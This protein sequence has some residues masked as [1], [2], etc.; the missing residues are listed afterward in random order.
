MFNFKDLPRSLFLLSL[1]VIA[2]GLPSSK[3]LMSLGQFGVVLAWILKGEYQHS[4][5]NFFT[6]KTLLV[7]SSLFLLHLIG[8]IYTQNFD[9][10]LRDVRVKLPIFILPFFSA[11][12]LPLK[13]REWFW[14]LHFFVLSVLFVS[15]IGFY[16]KF[17][18]PDLPFSPFVSHIRF[19]LMI[20]FALFVTLYFLR[21]KLIYRGLYIA[22]LI[23]L[24]SALYFLGSLTAFVVL[25]LATIT[26]IIV[27]PV[28][29]FSLPVKL[30]LT[31]G[32]LLLSV[33][34]F[35][36]NYYQ[37]YKEINKEKE[38]PVLTHSP[39]GEK[40]YSD[41]SF[42][43]GFTRE[44]GYYIWQNIAWEELRQ[45]WQ[46]VSN[47]PFDDSTGNALKFTLVRYM[48]SKGLNKDA[49]DFKK[50]SPK[51]I[52]AIEKGIANYRLTNMN[53]LEKRIY[54]TI[55]ELEVWQKN[56]NPSGHSLVMRFI[57][58]ESAVNVWLKHPFI[59]VGTGDI[60]DEVMK[61]QKE[62]SKLEEGFYKH[63]HNQYLTM[64]ATF[65]VVGFVW[66]L[67][68]IFYPIVTLS[69]HT[70]LSIAF[71]AIVVVSYLNED[72]LETQAGVTFVMLFSTLL[73]SSKK[74]Y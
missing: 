62:N 71:S 23:I 7:L 17:T 33:G 30:S 55:W 58:W 13:R 63:P 54:Q 28:R 59:G 65:G 9:Y 50:L 32:I 42:S 16:R 19:G 37:P 56:G 43:E 20:D 38:L 66:F 22:A 64:L 31:I 40:Y 29:Y 2:I 61:W 1:I 68:W 21:Q 14:I 60:Y 6:N 10:G 27:F 12:F 18:N 35:Y 11:P 73:Y 36:F 26:V 47:K 49:S 5:K 39:N 57:Y 25:I 4:V 3:F 69:K 46:K 44:N 48:T 8:L 67:F 15:G 45:S 74:V 53:K 24:L 41:L 34:V 51:D 52:Q 70:L 72:T